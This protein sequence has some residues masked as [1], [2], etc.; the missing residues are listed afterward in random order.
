M[1]RFN[2]IAER[3][4]ETFPNADLALLHKAYVYT[5]KV[6]QGQ[7][8][9]SGEPY[10]TH[11][12][13]VALT[14]AEMRL[15]EVTVAAALLHDT[16]EDTLVEDQDVVREFGEEIG[17]LVSGLTKISKI[18]F[19]SR[20]ERQAENFRKMLLAM[21]KDIRIILIKLADRL[22]NMQTLE[23]MEEDARRRIAQETLDIY[24]P[25]SHLL[26]IYWMKQEL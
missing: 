21:S 18:E 20:H 22:H 14:L 3:V 17:T 10:L 1:P 8:R 19:A 11:P 5:A 2:D 24:A 6:H 26:G 4:Q 13:A 7:M 23:F 15:D 9:L 16:V 12:L 25:M